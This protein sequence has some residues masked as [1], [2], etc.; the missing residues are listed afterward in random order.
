MAMVN[1]A[2]TSSAVVA[3]VVADGSGWRLERITA[4]IDCGTIVSPNG[5]RAQ[6]EGGVIFGLGSALTN[7]VRIVAGEVQQ[8]N[9]D[10]LRPLRSSEVPTIQIV[11]IP[12]D[13]KPTGGGEAVIPPTAAAV[14][15]AVAAL[16]GVRQRSLPLTGWTGEVT[17]TI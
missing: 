4:S 6:M 7:E 5:L 12:S 9:F 10:T 13:E 3:E 2:G 1:Y 15:N 16:T 11:L 8:S 17:E 14:A